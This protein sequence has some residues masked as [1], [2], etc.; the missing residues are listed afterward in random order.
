M[1]LT[2]VPHTMSVGHALTA[3]LSPAAQN[4]PFFLP[5]NT[6]GQHLPCHNISAAAVTAPV[7][8]WGHEAPAGSD[9]LP[10]LP[11]SFPALLTELSASRVTSC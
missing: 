7:L 9:F 10:W 11:S 2:G 4:Q 5:E 6:P 3:H 8:P 1:D